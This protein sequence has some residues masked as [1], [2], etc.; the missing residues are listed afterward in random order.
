MGRAKLL[1][2]VYMYA[3]YI[4]AID[5][6]P[7]AARKVRAVAVARS[8]VVAKE[9]FRIFPDVARKGMREE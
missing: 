8:S 4:Y 2:C 6:Q 7:Q 3:L 9:E 1:D 5:S